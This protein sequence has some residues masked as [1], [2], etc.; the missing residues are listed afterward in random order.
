MKKTIH[1]DEYAL[2]VALLRDTRENAGMT[3]TELATR[4]DTTQSIVS[5]IERGERRLDLV[6][7]KAWCNAIDMSLAHFAARFEQTCEGR[8]NLPA[9]K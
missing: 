4:L 7:L 3:Q 8:D 6:E 2:L 5:K 9:G 1:T